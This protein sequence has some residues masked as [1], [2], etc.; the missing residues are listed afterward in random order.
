MGIGKEISIGSTDTLSALPIEYPPPQAQSAKEKNRQLVRSWINAPIRVDLLLEIELLALGFA[1]GLEDA[2]TFPD[3]F[4][5]TSNQT[6]NTISLSIGAAGL[7]PGA[8]FYLANIGFSLSLF[9]V[10]CWAMGQTGNYVGST[11]RLWVLVSSLIQTAMVFAAG[12]VLNSVPNLTAQLLEYPSQPF[13]WSAL[14]LLAFSAGGQVAMARGVRVQE[15][16]TAN[17][18]SAYVD[19]FVDPNLYAKHN[20]SRNRRVAFLI[21]LASGCIVGGFMHQNMTSAMT[22]FVSGIVK[23]IITLG[24][25]FNKSEDGSL[26]PRGELTLV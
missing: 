8:N 18:S 17:A 10:G 25:A 23:L 6:G 3:F 22:L 4:C 21:V 2:T 5:Y 19:L 11:R 26:A 7:H 9:I 14:A 12:W 15:I 20:R 1:T 24:F 16:S 13:T